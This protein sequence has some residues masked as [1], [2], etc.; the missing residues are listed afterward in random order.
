MQERIPFE[1]KLIRNKDLVAIEDDEREK[2]EED[3]KKAKKQIVSYTANRDT[4]FI[5][6]PEKIKKPIDISNNIIEDKNDKPIADIGIQSDP[7][8]YENKEK[9]KYNKIKL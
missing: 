5:P 8:D 6:Y 7:I 4:L 9:V 1:H 3:R 2:M